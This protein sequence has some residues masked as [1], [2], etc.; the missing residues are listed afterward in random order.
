[1]CWCQIVHFLIF[2]AKLSGSP[3]WCQIVRFYYLGAKLSYH[4]Y[5][6][7]CMIC[8]SIQKYKC[9]QH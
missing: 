8:Y 7:N 5:E 6:Y 3:Y 2:G 1:M 4:I 9:A